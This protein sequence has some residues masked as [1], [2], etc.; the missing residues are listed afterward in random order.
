MPVDVAIRGDHYKNTVLGPLP[1]PTRI[2]KDFGYHLRD[3]HGTSVGT[4]VSSSTLAKGNQ[5]PKTLADI[6]H[7]HYIK[8]LQH[9]KMY[10]LRKLED[11][12]KF[13]LNRSETQHTIMDNNG[14][15]VGGVGGEGGSID[16][17]TGVIALRDVDVGEEPFRGAW[18][19][20]DDS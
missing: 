2:Q 6:Q 4:P 5:L 3:P 9:Q 16:L 18:Y 15:P 10:E 11:K 17:A 8:T 12:Q 14:N 13:G 20:L 19:G 1:S 7:G